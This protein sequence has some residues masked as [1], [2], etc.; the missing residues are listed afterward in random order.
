MFRVAEKLSMKHGRINCKL[1]DLVLSRMGVACVK[2]RCLGLGFLF[3][4]MV[5]RKTLH[6]DVCGLIIL[7][8][9]YNF[10]VV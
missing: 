6:L 3:V 5:C 2:V 4:L 7:F 10:F 8:N 9:V 1:Y